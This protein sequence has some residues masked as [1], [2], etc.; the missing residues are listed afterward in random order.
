MISPGTLKQLAQAIEQSPQAQRDNVSL[1]KPLLPDAS[2]T[3]CSDNDIPGQARPAYQGSGF[4]LYLVDATAH[5][6]SLTNDLTI[7]CGVVLALHDDDD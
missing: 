2:L 5:C 7:A 1:F 6:A 3:C 4:D